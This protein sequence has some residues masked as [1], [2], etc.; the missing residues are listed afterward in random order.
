MTIQ[1]LQMN[2]GDLVMWIDADCPGHGDL[3]IVTALTQHPNHNDPCATIYWTLEPDTSGSFP[4]PHEHIEVL[5]E[6]S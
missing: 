3:G 6:T 2:V 5:S 4:F 1:S